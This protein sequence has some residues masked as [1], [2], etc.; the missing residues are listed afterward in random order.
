MPPK[1]LA[2]KDVPWCLLV[3]VTLATICHV[4]VLV[5]NYDTARGLEA[6]GK[7]TKGWSSVGLG[8]SHSLQHELDVSM[9]DMSNGLL[10]AINHTLR[11]SEILN[12]VTSLA[13]I[14]A[15]HVAT[16]HA[17]KAITLLQE[18]MVLA[19]APLGVL[20]GLL[21]SS[22][23][24]LLDKLM[25]KALD[26]LDLLLRNIKPVLEEVGKFILKFGDRIQV[27]IETFSVT[28]DRVQKLFDQIMT[29]FS[30]HG[31][32][33][34]QIREEVFN[35]FDVSDT[36]FV[37]KHD[38]K[39]VARLYEISAFRGKKADELLD[40]YDQDKDGRLNKHEFKMFVHDPTLP[41]SMPVVLR[42]YAK[43]LARSPAT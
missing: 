25:K 19:G 10:Q 22:V 8:L 7:S 32:G 21:T 38:L 31:I 33:E 26:A 1:S 24:K 17:T 4:C 9:M 34:E 27:Y 37:S 13:G 20:P 30:A 12:T 11:T 23:D 36:G 14:V 5:G 18:H 35:L 15:D 29:S 16:S 43:R 2:T 28:L 39:D 42:S 6:I 40:K 3:L 41:N